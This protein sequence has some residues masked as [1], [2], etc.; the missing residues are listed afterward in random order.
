MREAEDE[1]VLAKRWREYE[2]CA[3]AQ[4]FA[5][6]HLRLAPRFRPS[7]APSGEDCDVPLRLSGDCMSR[8]TADPATRPV[9]TTSARLTPRRR[10]TGALTTGPRRSASNVSRRGRP[11]SGC[12]CH[13]PVHKSRSGSAR[14]RGFVH[15]RFPRLAREPAHVHVVDQSLA[16]LN[17]RATVLTLHGPHHARPPAQRVRSSPKKSQSQ[18]STIEASGS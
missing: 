8:P 4:M 12:L 3:A 14:S 7:A 1:Y 10:P 6:P 17:R 2:D 13:R 9:R 18:S 15:G 5:N 11:S 16:Q